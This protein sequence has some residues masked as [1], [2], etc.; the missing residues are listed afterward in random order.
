MRAGD[1]ILKRC[2]VLSLLV[3][4]LLIAV[5]YILYLPKYNPLR[6]ANNYISIKTQLVLKPAR[7]VKNNAA[8]ILVLIHRAYKSAVENKRE[9]FNSLSQSA[10]AFVLVIAGGAAMLRLMWTAERII[11]Q[12]RPQQYAYLNYCTLRI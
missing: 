1:S 7:N 11:K 2:L 6:P 10:L 9:I 3:I 5:T 8:G 4:Y 12:H